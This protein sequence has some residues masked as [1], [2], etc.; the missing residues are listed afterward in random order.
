MNIELKELVPPIIFRLIGGVRK[1]LER[2]F[3]KSL[4]GVLHPFDGIPLPPSEVSWILDI[5]ANRG[6]VAVAALRSYPNSSVICIEPVTET[7]K[8]L[9]KNLTP[10]SS[11]TVLKKYAFSD[12]AG[13]GEIN[14]TNFDGANSILPQAKRHQ[15][16]NPHVVEKGKEIITLKRLDDEFESFPVSIFDIVKIDV[17]GFEVQVIQGGAKFFADHVRSI[18]I[19]VS[20][21]RDASLGDQCVYKIF[22]I[23]DE[24]G[25]ALV[26]LIDLYPGPKDSSSL[27]I[28]QVDCVFLNTKFIKN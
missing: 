21:M 17:E 3:S 15:E 8:I 28:A 12:V 13:V 4:G 1:R 7:F 11:R 9:E 20:F 19:E 23:L 6:D 14:I 22:K 24:L 5:G 10:F 18:L 16:W 26:N 2:K 25:Y 27:L